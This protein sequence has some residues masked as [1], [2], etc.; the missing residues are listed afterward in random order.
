MTSKAPVDAVLVGAGRRGFRNFGGYALDHPGDLRIIAVAEPNDALRDRFRASP[1]HPLRAGLPL[2]GIPSRP[3]AAG[4]GPHQRLQRHHPLRLHDGRHGVRLPGAHREAGRRHTGAL[5]QPRPHRRQPRRRRL[6]LP[7]AQEHRLLRRA[8][9]DRPLR[10]PR[11]NS[12]TSATGRTSPTG[13]WPTASYA[14][15]GPTRPR[16]GP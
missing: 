1:R 12:P 10:P 4:P 5:R 16:R 3:P 8:A 7:R 6:G 14:A 2:L 13:T 15:T 11:R 9:R